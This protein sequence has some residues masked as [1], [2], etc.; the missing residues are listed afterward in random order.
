MLFRRSSTDKRKSI[1]PM[2]MV[3]TGLVL[4]AC[5]LIWPRLTALHGSMSS[6]A[7]DFFQGFLGGI[8]MACEVMGTGSMLSGRKRKN[9][10]S[11]VIP[12]E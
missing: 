11:S 7:A 9:E 6:S 10:S 8:G 2:T 1:P 4:I 12:R 3:G 5:S